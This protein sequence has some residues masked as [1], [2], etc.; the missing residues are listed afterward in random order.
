MLR[1]LGRTPRAGRD[2]R[3]AVYGTLLFN[4]VLEAIDE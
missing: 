1:Y 2:R 3:D 4:P